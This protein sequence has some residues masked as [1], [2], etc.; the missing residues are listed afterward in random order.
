MTT[1][2][3]GLLIAN[4]GTPDEPTTDAVKRYLK[5]FLNDARVIDLP[6]WR[7]QPL[8]NTII[9]PRRSPKVASATNLF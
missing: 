9:L 4:L 6:K 3:I 8:L 5:Q 7:W 1:Q 2:K